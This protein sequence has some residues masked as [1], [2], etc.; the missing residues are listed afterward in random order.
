M[1]EEWADRA[2]PICHAWASPCVPFG[3][4]KSC[5]AHTHTDRGSVHVGG[6]EAILCVLRT[7]GRHAVD[8]F[9]GRTRSN[10]MER[11]GASSEKRKD[12]HASAFS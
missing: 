6:W 8:R 4:V 9:E 7:G 2:Y 1:E 11:R 10:G 5:E 3:M 12:S